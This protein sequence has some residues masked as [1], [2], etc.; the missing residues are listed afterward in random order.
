MEK[1][2]RTFARPGRVVIQGGWSALLALGLVACGGSDQEAKAPESSGDAYEEPAAPAEDTPSSGSS[3]AAGNETN[4]APAAPREFPPDA[5]GETRTV[6]LLADFVKQRREKVRPCYDAV[7]KKQP[8][9]KGD[10]V[11]RFTLDPQGGVKKTEYDRGQSTID[12]TEIA[13]C[14]VAEL[15]TWQFPASSRGMQTEVAYPFNFNPRR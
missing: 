11:I 13:D 14:V 2:R 10:L 8:E 6:Q 3:S 12:S 5:N 15:K 7:Q 4:E 1:I 9:L